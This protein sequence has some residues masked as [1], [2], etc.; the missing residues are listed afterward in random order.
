MN[1]VATT[2]QDPVRARRPVGEFKTWLFTPWDTWFF[3]DGRPWDAPGAFV[4]E[5]AF[6]PAARTVMGAVRGA[7]AQA[8]G[9]NWHDP[10]DKARQVLGRVRLTGPMVVRLGAEGKWERLYPV[11]ANL[12]LRR[13][14]AGSSFTQARPPSSGKV[15]TDAGLLHLPRFVSGD[16]KLESIENHW[17]TPRGFLAYLGEKLIEAEDL[18]EPGDLA[19]IEA[20]PG[21]RRDEGSRSAR[22]GAFFIIGHARLHPGVALAARIAVSGEAPTIDA[23]RNVKLG[24][25]SRM[26]ALEIHGGDV[27]PPLKAISTTRFTRKIKIV[28]VTHANFEGDWRGTPLLKAWQDAD[29]GIQLT[30]LGDVDVRVVSAAIYP[31]R[32]EGGFSLGPVEGSN[33]YNGGHATHALIPAGSVWFCEVVEWRDPSGTG[34]GYDNIDINALI[35]RLHGKQLGNERELGRG[36]I[37]VG[38][39]Q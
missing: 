31:A 38:I 24:G 25:E 39:W 35:A 28:F 23:G 21:I 37:A 13:G 30:L 1:A 29:G 4:S 36:E 11:P 27:I 9:V 19:T 26:A 15:A 3:K 2:R 5:G 10:A 17:L 12:A 32:Y 6:P 8:L 7:Y 18:I 20:R 14:Q 22:Q 33:G 34:R 16:D